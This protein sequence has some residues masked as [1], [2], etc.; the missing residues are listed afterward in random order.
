MLE[1]K[2][3]NINIGETNILHDINL[4][5]MTGEIVGLL[6]PNGIGKSTVA[7]VL[8]GDDA[9]QTTG[10]ILYNG[11]LINK[12]PVYERAKLGLYYISQN[13][14]SIEGVTNAEM[15]RLALTEKGIKLNLY[16][17][18]QKMVAI[19]KELNL[20]QEFIHKN[21]N[22]GA[23]GGERKKI[24]LLHLWML[25]PELVIL[26]EIDSGLDVDSLKIVINSLKKYQKQ[27]NATYILITHNTNV[28][29]LMNSSRI[30]ILN[31]KTIEEEGDLTLAEKIEKNGFTKTIEVSENKSNE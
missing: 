18:H 8:M 16:E 14:I 7:K 4:K 10:K 23:S 1:I 30:L 6:G 17:F 9:Y 21:I 15:L 20:A 25:E 29:K 19:C 22:E 5:I 28:L 2:N 26:D 13:P 27:Y 3:L 11:K 31:N 12:M 24:E